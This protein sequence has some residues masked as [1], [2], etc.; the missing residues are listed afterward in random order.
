MRHLQVRVKRIKCNLVYKIN[1]IIVIKII[2]S[3]NGARRYYPYNAESVRRRRTRDKRTKEDEERGVINEVAPTWSQ[4]NAHLIT[5]L[6]QRNA[7]AVHASQMVLGAR[8]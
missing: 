5:N 4:L 1:A 3:H 2:N 7:Q 8:R 6:I